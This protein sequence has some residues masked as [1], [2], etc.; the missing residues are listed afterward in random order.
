[1]EKLK[2]NSM[3]F[4]NENESVVIVFFVNLTNHHFKYY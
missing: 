4:E 2:K 1:M 3:Y